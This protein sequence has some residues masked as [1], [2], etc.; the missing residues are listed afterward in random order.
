MTNRQPRPLLTLVSRVPRHV[1]G[2]PVTAIVRVWPPG[3]TS[4]CKLC[5]VCHASRGVCLVAFQGDVAIGDAPLYEDP[6][7]RAAGAA[8][9]RLH[10]QPGLGRCAHKPPG[11]A[12]A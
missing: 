5:T 7:V 3:A 12:S 4:R 8:P 6:A 11:S 10:R 1:L 9:L 2:V